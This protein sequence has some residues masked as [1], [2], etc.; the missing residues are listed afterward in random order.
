MRKVTLILLFLVLVCQPNSLVLA[1]HDEI[2]TKELETPSNLIQN[3]NNENF[4]ENIA[5]GSQGNWVIFFGTPWCPH[6]QHFARIFKEFAQ[7][8]S[9]KFDNLNYGH[10]NCELYLKTCE[11]QNVTAYPTVYIYSKG[12]KYQQNKSRDVP[13]QLTFAQNLVNSLISSNL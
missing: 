2:L 3:Q 4:D 11:T 13:G 10:V 1:E 6:C 7:K 9:E 8:A 5:N 12:Y